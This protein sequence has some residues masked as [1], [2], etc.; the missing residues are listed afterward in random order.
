M[1]DGGELAVAIEAT[2]RILQENPLDSD[3]HFIR[4][5]AELGL[6]DHEAAAGSFRRTLYVDPTFGLA[7]FKLGRAHEARGDRA[8]ACRAYEWAL[9]APTAGDGGHANVL[10]QVDLG[11]VEAACAIRLHALAEAPA[12]PTGAAGG[13]G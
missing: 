3:A 5:L 2:A 7:A 13:P 10:D 1:A 8:A 6:G 9:R 4:G 12:T 11:D